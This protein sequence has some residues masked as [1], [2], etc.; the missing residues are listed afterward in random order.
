MSYE[1]AKRLKAG[2]KDIKIVFGGPLFLNKKYINEVLNS[3]VVDMAIIGEGEHSICKL[4]DSIVKNQDISQVPG[5]AFI[6][7]RETLVTKSAPA[8]DLDSLP[9]LD[10]TDLSLTDY[11]DSRHIS[12]MA[13]RGCIKRCYFCSDAPCWPGYRTMIFPRKS[14]HN[15]ELVV[16]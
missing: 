14:G 15:E 8:V 1:L 11:D 13:S 10:F 2:N 16:A 6:K 5:I 3:N 9:F 4:A 7:N 12:L